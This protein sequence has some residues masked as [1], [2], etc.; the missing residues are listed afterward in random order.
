MKKLLVLALF[1]IVLFNS[2]VIA[3]IVNG[4]ISGRI[5]DSNNQAPLTGVNV[6]LVG[7]KR[8]S[9]SDNEGRFLISN[10]PP[11]KYQLKFTMMGYKTVIKSN[12]W[13]FANQMT[14]LNVVMS[15]EVL[16]MN[17]IVVTPGKYSLA[18]SHTTKRQ[19]F[20]HH[21]ITHL[22]ATMDDICRV[23]QTIPGITVSNDYS[24]H[25]HVRGG[26]HDENLI[27]LDGTEI[28]DPYH[29][30]NVWGAVG[31]INMDV[32][33]DVQVMTG[34]FPAQFGDKLSSIVQITTKEGNKAL[35][36]N[37]GIG[38][39][40]VKALIQGPIPGGSWFLSYRKSFLKQA[41][42]IL[43]SPITFSPSFYDLQSKVTF[44][45]SPNQK[46]VF[47]ILHSADNTYL[48]QWKNK[49]KLKSD[50]GNFYIGLIWKS[51]VSPK[52]FFEMVFSRGENFW[53]NK[54][55]DYK[56]EKLNLAEYVWQYNIDFHALKNHN[57][58]AGITYKDIKYYYDYQSHVS[59]I[60]NEKFESLIK[61]LT[62]T[63]LIRPRTYKLS[64][65][66][67]DEWK[68]L[69][70]LITNLGIR[71]D[72]FEYNK[73]NQFSPRLGF[74]Y[75]I[76]NNLVLR[77]AWGYYYQA[78]NYT[79]LNSMKGA[80]YNPRAEKSVHYIL[81]VE[82]HFD[83]KNSIRIEGYY[84]N[85]QNMIGYYI[86]DGSKLQY[87]N[88]YHGFCKG[89]EIFLKLGIDKQFNGW[90]SYAYSISKIEETVFD[91]LTFTLK[92]KLNYRYTDQP[93][94][95]T[96][97][98][99]FKVFKNW[100]IDLRWRYLSGIPYTPVYPVWDSN[101]SGKHEVIDFQAGE[102][103]SSRYPA[104]HRLDL[105]LMNTFFFKK[106]SLTTFLEIKNVYNRKNV[107][108]YDYDIDALSQFNRIAYHTLPRIPS[109]EVCL[110]F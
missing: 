49:K 9:A 68:I 35:S 65:F 54:I 106:C 41:V 91:P 110:E 72:H 90:L 25:F 55:G 93:H 19:I 3:Q 29:L 69:N 57:L 24:A 95:L 79:E 45:V 12:I 58:R 67:Q 63:S 33:E 76:T 89:L 20:S 13:I 37:I 96:L 84:K 82:Q 59:S 50:Y 31:I 71:F 99:N 40:G 104:Y 22:P 5:I 28:F 18:Q 75:C 30:K 36:G 109:I 77:T 64:F 92:Q 52:L 1:I 44:Q 27:L 94:N 43:N 42:E 97:V 32:I 51:I 56:R 17:E 48:E 6:A 103:H 26:E 70:S 80:N 46:F 10:L 85:L 61:G 108:I 81:G 53:N 107:L 47:N 102:Y 66:L 4:Q 60:Q 16:L 88:P 7:T 62:D 38:G 105:R 39:T 15:P 8:G 78:P 14:Q 21:D 2:E 11:G 101:S 74:A 86:A 23:V 83:T 100:N 73:D 98:L 87:G 34:G